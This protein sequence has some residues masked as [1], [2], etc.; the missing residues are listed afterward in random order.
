MFFKAIAPVYS[1]T[2]S[3]LESRDSKLSKLVGVSLFKL[4]I[5]I[6]LWDFPGG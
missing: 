2:S 3:V 1:S 4:A 5:L 6:G